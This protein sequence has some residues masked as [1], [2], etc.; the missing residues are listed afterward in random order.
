MRWE[1]VFRHKIIRESVNPQLHAMDPNVP[2]AAFQ[3]TFRLEHCATLNPYGSESCSYSKED[4]ALAYLRDA[5]H[6]LWNANPNTRIGYF[7]KVTRSSAAMR[8]DEKPLARDTIKRTDGQPHTAGVVGPGA[9]E[10]RAVPTRRLRS[11]GS[12]FGEDDG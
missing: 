10:G 7:R 1:C 5:Q 12:L 4:C 8:A 11:I 9:P 2:F 3:R 6:T